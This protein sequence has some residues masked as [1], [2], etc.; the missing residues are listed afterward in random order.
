MA[1]PLYALLLSP[2]EAIPAYNLVLLVIE[3]GLLFE[4]R[5]HI[6]FGRVKTLLLGG[7]IGIPIGA[8]ALKHLPVAATSMFISVVTCTFAILLLLKMRIVFK[9]NGRTQVSVGLISGLL[10][11]SVGQAGPPVIMYSLS[12]D[13]EK[14]TLR[15]T[16]LTYFTFLCV[17]SILS[18]WK[19]GLVGRDTVITAAITIVPALVVS[20][21]AVLLKNLASEASFR[22]AILVTVIVVSLVN[23]GKY[24]WRP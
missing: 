5:K 2:K 6:Q 13:W 19:L 16:L 23:V 4:A 9:E 20:Y 22:R 3:V 1:V 24:F 14:N 10:G 21:I 8:V 12:R 18:Y 7:W 11:G 15:T 17:I